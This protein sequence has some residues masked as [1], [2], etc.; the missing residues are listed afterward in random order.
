M[1]RLLLRQRGL[2]LP[3][4]CRGFSMSVMP[5]SLS[6]LVDTYSA[7][8]VD[9]PLETK[10]ATAAAL[11]VLGDAIAQQR[12]IGPYDRVRAI[13]FILFDG[14]YRGGFQHWAFPLIIDSCQGETLQAAVASISLS[15]A[16]MDHQFLFAAVECTAF[17]QLL[18]VPVIYYP[19]FFAITGAVQ[20]LSISESARRAR[21]RFTNLTIRN[22]T[23]WVPAQF[24]Q[25]FFIG[26][27]WQVPYTCAMGLV[28]N[29][30]LSAAAGSAQ[31]DVRPHVGSPSS[32][33]SRSQRKSR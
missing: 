12:E 20:G 3:R 18:V 27:E 28:W 10:V 22:W 6:L 21:S 29:V 13:S 24:V 8:L 25:F 5:S 1:N 7:A 16:I 19:L 32:R 23:F 14:A 26:I 30:I 4:S 11:A 15:G 9:H 17:N 33:R 31:S 2:R